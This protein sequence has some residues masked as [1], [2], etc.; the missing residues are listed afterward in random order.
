[1]RCTECGSEMRFTSEPIREKYRGEELV[2]TG[3]GRWVCD[4]CG[5]DLMEADEADRL[6]RKLADAYAARKGL[7]LPSEIRELRESLGMSQKD[8]EHLLGVSTPTVSRWETGAVQQSKPVDNLMRLIRDV[9]EARKHMLKLT[10]AQREPPFY[11]SENRI[12]TKRSA[13]FAAQRY[14]PE[15]VI[16]FK[17]TDHGPTSKGAREA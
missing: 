8:F 16:E 7:L 6:G 3:I 2:I 10:K 11:G 12:D 9:P 5:N 17:P 4:G 14:N 15:S 1:M 13:P